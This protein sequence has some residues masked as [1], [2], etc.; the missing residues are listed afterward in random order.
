MLKEDIEGI[1]ASGQNWHCTDCKTSR[2]LSR[3]ADG[4]EVEC[5]KSVHEVKSY[6]LIQEIKRD[7]KEVEKNLGESINKLYE[8]LDDSVKV[9]EAQGVKINQCNEQIEILQSE[10]LLLKKQILECQNLSDDLEQRLLANNIEIHGVPFSANENIPSIVT[11][12]GAEL[13][14]QLTENC[15]DVCYRSPQKVNGMPGGI[16][17]RFINHQVKENF[18]AKRRVKRNLSTR[19]LTLD[20]VPPTD[21][22]IYINEALS[23]GRRK[24][25]NTVRER[26]KTKNYAYLWIRGGKILVRKV[27]K[28]KVI[29]LRHMADICKL[30]GE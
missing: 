14:V 2:E 1:V 22:P 9:I 10:N 25:L 23:P 28:G 24:V 17:V 15:F 6:H 8:R 19:H 16:Q 29:A 13:G 3:N 18:L 30:D 26:K 11:K 21:V 20:G 5:N 4:K 12:I 27:E 7:F